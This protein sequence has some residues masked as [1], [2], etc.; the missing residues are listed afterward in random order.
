MTT[1]EISLGTRVQVTAGIGTVRWTGTNPAFATGNWVG[2]ELDGKTGKNNGS[3]QGES[4]FECEPGYGVF[5]RKSTV[6]LAEPAAAAPT[7]KT[8][9][10]SSTTKLTSSPSAPASRVVSSTP[11]RAST[12]GSKAT[13]RPSLP[14]ATRTVPRSSTATT[15]TTPPRSG[16]APVTAARR[17][18][19]AGRPA[20]RVST[21]GATSAPQRAS[22]ASTPISASP[23]PPSSLRPSSASL[24]AASASRGP[25]PS[26]E[27]GSMPPP[28][29]P[30]PRASMLPP[31]SPA[32]SVAPSPSRTSTLPPSSPARSV[33]PSPSR[34]A[35]PPPPVPATPKRSSRA[36]SLVGASPRGSIVPPASPRLSTIPPVSPSP[37]VPKVTPIVPPPL[38]TTGPVGI[39]A[40]QTPSS[41]AVS[42]ASLRAES[43]ASALGTETERDNASLRTATSP[44]A[45]TVTLGLGVPSPRVARGTHGR[46]L[47][48]SSS[49]GAPP[50]PDVEMVALI[51]SQKREI[52]D[53]KIKVRLLESR[54]TEDQE[55]IKTLEKK[56]TDADQLQAIRAKLQTKFQ[57]QQSVLVNAQRVARD[58]QSDNAR[59]ESRAAEALDQL[60]MATLDREV[61]EE[62]AEAA[63]ADNERLAERIAELELEV[64]LVKEENAEYE[65]PVLG[66]E[67]ERSS[68]AYV[69]LEKH[70]ER[71]KEALIR[72]RDM[73]SESEKEHR[74]KITDLEKEL[75]SREDVNSRLEL[76]ESKLSSSE[77]QV[78]DLKQQLD[79]ALHAEDLLVELTERN[80]QMSERLEEMRVT[81]ED[82]EAL[83]ELNDELEE[84]HVETEKQL[85]EEIALLS[86]QL[87][88]ERSRSGELES[89]VADMETTIGQFRELVA[90]LQS[91]IDG[92]RVQQ[93]TQEHQSA[94]ASKE[95]QALLNL[96]LKLQSS[97]AKTQVKTLDVELKKL[98]AAQLADHLN[99]VQAY[100]PD[101]YLESE[102]DSTTALLFFNRV[103]AKID[104]LAN[105]VSQMHGLPAALQDVHSERLVGVCELRGKLRQF[106]TLN[107][108]F[109]AVM[110]RTDPEDYVSFGRVVPEVAGV[111]GKVDAWIGL[112]KS[113]EFNEGDCVRELDSL[114]SQFNH[115]AE[116]VFQR[117][118]LDACEH[119]LSLA[120]T[121]E[122]DLDNF[123]AAVGYVRHAIQSFISEDGKM[124]FVARNA[125]V[126]D[127]EVDLG[128]STLEE[129]VY[130]PVQDVL[131]QVRS[132]KVSAGKLS[133]VLEEA[134]RAQVALLPEYTVSL[135]ELVTSI[136][137][138]V[139]IALRLAQRIATHIG[140]LRSSKGQLR[141]ADIQTFL[142]EVTAPVGAAEL[143]PWDII[144]H[145]ITRLVMDLDNALPKFRNAAKSGQ[146][147]DL[148]T[149]APWL[150]R[151]VAIKE[152]AQYN[153]EA[154]RK[155]SRLSEELKDMLREVK[156]RDQTLQESGVKVETLE[157][158]L[159]ASRKQA[160]M[161]LELE[162]DIAKAKKQEKVYE[163]A[164]EAL[165][166]EQ[167]SLEAENARLRKN[168][169]GDGTAAP[170]DALVGVSVS[171]VEAGHLVDQIENLKSALRFLRA[172]NSLLK[173]KDLFND[174]AS[175]SPLRTA[176][177]EPVPKLIKSTESDSEDDA[178]LPVTP[179]AHTGVTRPDA[180]LALDTESKKLLKEVASFTAV[181]RIV[182][183]SG[184]GANGPAWRSRRNSPQAQL[185]R[186]AADRHALERKVESLA[187]R[188][189]ALRRL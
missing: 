17:A 15:T 179:R 96:N 88:E 69:Q 106:A 110:R 23:M 41:P 187:D 21:I 4:Y 59:L 32:R 122:D 146:T 164:I 184:L 102:V 94:T 171:G 124:E 126:S 28:A 49:A 19:L 82:L 178:D 139:D 81:I 180:R 92:L 25:T 149:P 18:T 11:S 185:R 157:R 66:L 86:L 72:L 150:A 188:V 84:N 44:T 101:P 62:K 170:G 141:L 100:L 35:M 54:R 105:A 99:I 134:V 160:D 123:A 36:S 61:A 155:V 152:A 47:S 163:D 31:P 50:A 148:E 154:E 38:E 120:Y 174:I 9:R 68:L 29:V 121:F 115:L 173:S 78:E 135:S 46:Q 145:F 132:V 166:A 144:G 42:V 109:A 67:G 108:R 1:P 39:V 5:V 43:P 30:A 129:A 153:A 107:R 55:R 142:T 103:A 93:A 77:A 60:E 58:L 140:S 83:K 64:A 10:P 143:A 24:S 89:I 175:L 7:P 176:S 162:N 85:D 118:G 65:K 111:E 16:A 181:P 87:R 158:R 75:S 147:I 125:D 63:E 40:V 37:R 113:E 76:A 114:L 116:V 48:T 73:T 51:S 138:A 177:L 14:G 80:L 71:L 57:E 95:S 20:A 53:F 165:Q 97:A 167:D 98:E 127:V 172:E 6:K 133:A 186:F 117:P 70:N 27:P 2:I 91:E 128:D 104:M 79:D 56:A 151:V 52:D 156:I 169:G 90:G 3:V 8:P 189:A 26:R 22:T 136:S 168:G 45:S 161:I 137:N 159:E 130:Q 119:Q 33:A 182:D 12:P 183:I 112:V 131:D 34:S 13:P 74:T